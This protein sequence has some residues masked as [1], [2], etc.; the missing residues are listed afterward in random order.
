MKHN[1]YP[2]MI[3]AAGGILSLHYS[4]VTVLGE[5]RSQTGKSTAVLV[6][7]ALLGYELLLTTLVVYQLLISMHLFRLQLVT[8]SSP[9]RNL[10]GSYI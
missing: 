1:F 8:L 9:C 3:M 7:L 2:A 10:Q 4:T 6:A 5:G